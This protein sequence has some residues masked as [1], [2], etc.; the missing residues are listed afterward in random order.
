MTIRTIIVDDEPL[1][2]S[3]IVRALRHD[4]DIEVVC[5]CGDG[6]A[7]IDA[8]QSIQPDLLFLDVHMPGFSG[9]E[10]LTRLDEVQPLI[11]IFVTA[12][13]DYAIEAFDRNAVDYILKPF[14]SERIERAVARAKA[15]LTSPLDGNYATQ[16][17]QALT[18]MQKQQ[19]YLDRI[20]VPVQ[21]RILLLDAKNIDWVE[22]DR[23]CVLVHAGK[24]VYEMRTTLSS[25]ESQ[26]NPKQF[27]RIHR[28]TLVN[29]SRVKEIHPWFHGH[30]KVILIDGRELRMS[31]YQSESAKQLLGRLTE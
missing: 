13:R 28:S 21:G 11:T 1:V 30:H 29:V 27:V 6:I 19:Q 14:G 15:R 16:L 18:A 9:L 5:E 8:I 26:L 23:N 31:R 12:H 10:V 4:K 17:L 2:R 20:A 7:A 25:L 3:S 24:L 22:A